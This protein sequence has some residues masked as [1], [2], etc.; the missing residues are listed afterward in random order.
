MILH[1]GLHDKSIMLNTQGGKTALFL[2]SIRGRVEV[3]TLL[4][5]KEAGAE[6]KVYL[7]L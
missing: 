3:V 6:P 2:A 1:V 5:E 4:L 7:S